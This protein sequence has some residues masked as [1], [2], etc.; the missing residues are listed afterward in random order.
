MELIREWMGRSEE[1]RES[2]MVQMFSMRN[3][4]GRIRRIVRVT[5]IFEETKQ[6]FFKD[7]LFE[8]WRPNTSRNTSPLE[9][10]EP[11]YIN[12]VSK[13]LK[14]GYRKVYSSLDSLIMERENSISNSNTI[15]SRNTT[16]NSNTTPNR[17]TTPNSNTTPNRNTLPKKVSILTK[18]S[19]SLDTMRAWKREMDYVY[20]G[21]EFA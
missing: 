12:E 10:A 8:G 6:E 7:Y 2:V 5:L 9:L 16:P 20:A 18:G 14:G 3:E 15:P 21:G 13:A 11:A 4:S 17:N 1:L 19:V